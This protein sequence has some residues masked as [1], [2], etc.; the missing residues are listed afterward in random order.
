MTT[1]SLATSPHVIK[2]GDVKL[3]ND[4]ILVTIKSVKT[5]YLSVPPSVVFRLSLIPNSC[6]FPVTAWSNYAARV[7]VP[8]DFPT[9]VLPSGLPLTAKPDGVAE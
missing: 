7:T 6:C 2:Y 8:Q 9:L 1:R 5:R 4:A 3:I